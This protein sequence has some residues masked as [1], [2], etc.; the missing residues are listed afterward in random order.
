L[1]LETVNLPSSSRRRF[2]WRTGAALAVAALLFL[3]FAIKHAGASTGRLVNVSIDTNGTP[4]ILG[5]RLGNGAVRDITFRALGWAHVQ[6][7]ITIRDPSA[8]PAYRPD[9]L[10]GVANFYGTMASAIKNGL[11][12]T[13]APSSPLSGNNLFGPNPQ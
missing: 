11:V 7:R 13:K 1:I 3:L 2:G 12:P 8:P 5:I 6:V 10:Q 4:S 9:D